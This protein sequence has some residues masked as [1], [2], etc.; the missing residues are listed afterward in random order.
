MRRRN[1]PHLEAPGATYFV[2][3]RCRKGLELPPDA[4]DIVMTILSVRLA[5]RIDLDAAVVMP[6]HVHVIFR[7]VDDST[8]GSI[9]RRMK[10]GSSVQLN[11]RCRRTGPVL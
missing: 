4:R 11:R 1:L 2:T 10:G 3:F 8:L 5:N 9:L 6:D 7:I